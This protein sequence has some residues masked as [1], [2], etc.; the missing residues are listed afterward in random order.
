[1]LL[2]TAVMALPAAAKKKVPVGDR[3]DLFSPPVTFFANT[4]FHIRHGFT[5]TPTTEDVGKFSFALDLDGTRLTEDFVLKTP[6]S[7]PVPD[8]LQRHWVFNFPDGLT[9]GIHTFTGHFF[10]PCSAGPGPCDNPQEVIETGT[11]TRTVTFIAP[12]N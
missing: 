6:V 4:A 5:S 2:V 12:P 3:I 8:S 10:A 7:D 11:L 1:M 9:V